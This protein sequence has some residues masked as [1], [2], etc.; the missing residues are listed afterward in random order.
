MQRTI[1]KD[2]GIVTRE[3][4]PGTVCTVHA[5]CKADD[6]QPC[7]LVSEGSHR[8]AMVF[9]VLSPHLIEKT[10]EPRASLAMGIEGCIAQFSQSDPSSIHRPS[11]IYRFRGG[12]EQAKASEIETGVG[13]CRERKS[14]HSTVLARRRPLEGRAHAEHRLQP[15]RKIERSPNAARLARPALLLGSDVGAAGLHIPLH[16][17]DFGTC[18]RCIVLRRSNAF[19][20][21]VQL[22]AQAKETGP[23]QRVEP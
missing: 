7:A 10:G 9:G 20:K 12:A 15:P 8:R 1:K 5:R 19:C 23:H 2:A 3:G 6:Q 4:A 22:L 21:T 11:V 13:T 18:R 14:G 16:G 17:D